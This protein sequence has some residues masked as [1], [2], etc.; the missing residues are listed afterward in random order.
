MTTYILLRNNKES[1]PH[2][3]SGLKQIGLK[4]ED[5]V[6]VEG[7]SV[8]WLSPVDIIE[9]K[10]IVSVPEEQVFDTKAGNVF[11]ST[12]QATGLI[13]QTTVEKKQVYA[14]I[15]AKGITPK[16]ADESV[17]P[18]RSIVNAVNETSVA[19]STTPVLQTNYSMPP[20]AIKEMYVKNPEGKKPGASQKRELFI[21]LKRAMTYAG[22]IVIGIVI[23]I[24][25]VI[26]IRN[27]GTKKTTVAQQETPRQEPK[28]TRTEATSPEP[29]ATTGNEEVIPAPGDVQQP[30]IEKTQTEKKKITSSPARPL[31]PEKTGK[32][33][34]EIS[35]DP[36]LNSKTGEKTSQSR[37]EGPD[38]K[39]VSAEEIFSRVSVKCNDY[40][41]A[42]FGGIRNLQLTV[43]NESK[44]VLD[45]VT[46]ELQYL[47]PR[48]L[49]LR[50]EIIYFQSVAPEGTQTIAVKKSNRGVKVAFKITK[51]ESKEIA[52]STVGL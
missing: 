9:L 30:I 38:R 33:V 16:K 35:S 8:C 15:T 39:V 49:L 51:I 14:S 31:V 17:V 48:D 27:T 10:K 26:L 46:V 23:G 28:E 4:P 41:V 44:Y 11:E 43:K 13:Q 2:N 50:T 7:Q 21:H 20:G 42:S 18:A 29:A 5:L 34:D 24:V 3:L 1:G 45:R 37:N 22:L 47:K 52:I 40:I 32:T 19:G 12:N 36:D 25:T 6:W